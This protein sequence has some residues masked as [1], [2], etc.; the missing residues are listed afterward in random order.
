MLLSYPSR[1]SFRLSSD[2]TRKHFGLSHRRIRD[3]LGKKTMS[4]SYQMRM[5]KH[6]VPDFVKLCFVF[7]KGE[8][9]HLLFFCH[10]NILSDHSNRIP[11]ILT[12]HPAQNITNRDITSKRRNNRLR[13]QLSLL[14]A[15]SKICLFTILFPS[16][17][18][19]ESGYPPFP[20]L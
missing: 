12:R 5:V 18:F 15:Y 20:S 17:L 16:K 14:R 19:L 1:P 13:K 3:M 10:P 7:S 11:T 9:F 2:N 6:R 4:P 8:G